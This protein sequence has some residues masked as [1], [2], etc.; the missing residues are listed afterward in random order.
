L[1]KVD[2]PRETALLNSRRVS[3]ERAGFNSVLFDIQP[4]VQTF[5]RLCLRERIRALQEVDVLEVLS[6]YILLMQWFDFAVFDEKAV[7]LTLIEKRRSQQAEFPETLGPIDWSANG[8][9]KVAAFDIPFS[10]N[11]TEIDA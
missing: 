4:A 9:G 5:G 11:Q 7:G 10:Q 3:A 1:A 6:H 2:I 8:T